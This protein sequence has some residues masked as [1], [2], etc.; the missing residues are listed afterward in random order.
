MN[1][2]FQGNTVFYLYGQLKTRFIALF[3]VFLL[4]AVP[5]SMVGC[6][7]NP[8][9]ENIYFP[10]AKEANLQYPSVLGQGRVVLENNCLRLKSSN[11]LGELFDKGDLL[12]WPYGYSL[13]TQDNKICVVDENGVIVVKVGDLIKVGGGNVSLEIAEKYTGESIPGNFGG[14]FW[15]VSEVVKD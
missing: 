15:I 14:P 5:F 6:K 9:P 1:G 11:I 4:C 3:L 13:K 2:G 7:N 10:V 12:I 8:A